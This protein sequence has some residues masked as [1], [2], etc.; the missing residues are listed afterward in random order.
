MQ[1]LPCL[2]HNRIRF[3][4]CNNFLEKDIA[5]IGIRGPLYSISLSITFGNKC[6]FPNIRCGI[7]VDNNNRLDNS[8]CVQVKDFAKYL[9][10]R[11][12]CNGEYRID[13][14]LNK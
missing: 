6:E 8:W 5:D 14:T 10:T 2:G 3:L 12:R 9:W 1:T 7:N 13:E 4:C 11:K